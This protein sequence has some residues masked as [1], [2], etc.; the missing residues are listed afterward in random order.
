M[1]T[2]LIATLIL[3]LIC[4]QG[5]KLRDRLN[6]L[7]HIAL[8]ISLTASLANSA[9]A[10]LGHA[11]HWTAAT[12]AGQYNQLS[13]H[14]LLVASCTGLYIF[15]LAVE[16]HTI[17]DRH[18]Q[19]TIA[20]AVIA[21]AVMTTVVLLF[22]HQGKVLSFQIATF[23]DPLGFLFYFGAGVYYGWFRFAVGYW[24]IKRSRHSDRH[25]Q[26]GMR[27]AA[28]G[29]LII[30]ALCFV[31]AAPV[32]V[33]F[34]GGPPIITP[35]YLL[36]AVSSI[37]FPLIFLGLSYPLLIARLAAL[38]RYLRGRKIAE[39]TEGLWRLCR[40]AYPEVGLREAPGFLPRLF[41]G[42]HPDE[43]TRR[44]T[45]CFD[46]LAKLLAHATADTDGQ[47]SSPQ[48]VLLL[49][50]R[51][52][53][54]THAVTVGDVISPSTTADGIPPAGGTHDIQILLDLADILR[55]IERDQPVHVQLPSGPTERY[56]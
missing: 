53:D 52:H 18:F 47:S 9:S 14:I 8:I 41:S 36:G 12:T 55:E 11:Q 7:A 50:I 10:R 49:A 4:W 35:R 30:S 5:Y 24:M 22:L 28:C 6:G 44:I 1:P 25:L 26:I 29:L 43:P 3:Y 39:R 45:E 38:R 16:G 33:V 56:R 13:Q 15:R 2:E 46:A 19:R 21:S 40:R 20:A 37:A 23:R 32:A 27:L 54:E 51:R 31:R 42:T 17:R 48:A 34:L